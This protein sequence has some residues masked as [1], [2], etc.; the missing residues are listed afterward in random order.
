MAKYVDGFVLVVAKKNLEAYKKMA[1]EAGKVWKDFGALE[2]KEC[3]IEDEKPKHITFTF[4]KMTMAKPSE[5]VVFSYITYRSRK[6]RDQVN[7]KVMGYMDQKYADQK[8]VPM[9]FDMNRIAFGGFEA[10]VE[11]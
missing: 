4:R 3:V 1:K 10:M 11:Y 5:V 2:Y 7:A 9:P 6:H 8:D